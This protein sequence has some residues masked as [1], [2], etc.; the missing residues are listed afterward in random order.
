MLNL[1]ARVDFEE[2]PFASLRVYEELERSE[3]FISKFGR[4][5]K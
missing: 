5:R 4:Q 3:T 2:D 1:D